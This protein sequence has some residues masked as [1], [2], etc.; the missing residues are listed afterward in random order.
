MI[1]SSVAFWTKPY[2]YSKKL[3]ISPQ[4]FILLSPI[5]YNSTTGKTLVNKHIGFLIGASLDYKISKRF[6]MGINYKL[7]GSTMP[8]S[9][10]L[11][12]ILIGSRLIL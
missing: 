11:H 8:K 12:N 1:T 6:G 2:T 4:S 9:P 10:L 7:N 3:T 5:S